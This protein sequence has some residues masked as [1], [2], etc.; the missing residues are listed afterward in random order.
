MPSD[1]IKRERELT[2][3]HQTGGLRS[4][5]PKGVET[6]TRIIEAAAKI[7][8]EK[9]YAAL[10][11]AALR[12]AANVSSASLY[13]HFENKAAILTAVLS[14]AIHRSARTGLAA[15]ES[16]G[17]GAAVAP[18]GTDEAEQN[19]FMDFATFV[20]AAKSAR[21]RNPENAAALL[22]ALVEAEADSDQLSGAAAQAHRFAEQTVADQW[23]GFAKRGDGA[24]FAHVHLAFA[25]YMNQLAR[26]GAEREDIERVFTSYARALLFGA[27]AIRPDFLEDPQ[28]ASAR[29]AAERGMRKSA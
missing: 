19:P 15:R 29:D 4:K 20:A 8:V 28:M 14:H 23:R 1:E 7:I 9:G 26:C 10:S 3:P 13:H 2:K 16:P 12:R 5:T 25:G 27:I 22:A 6:R 17:D 24:F 11:M 21:G 18:D